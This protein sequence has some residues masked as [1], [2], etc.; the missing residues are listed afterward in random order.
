M[1]RARLSPTSATVVQTVRF[2]EDILDRVR[3]LARQ[4]DRSIGGQIRHIVREHV[5]AR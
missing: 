5:E 1:P 2:P 4:H 3:A